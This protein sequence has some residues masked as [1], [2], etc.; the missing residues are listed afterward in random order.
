MSI[1]SSINGVAPIWW[2]ESVLFPKLWS[3][4]N[5]ISREGYVI[6]PFF[7]YL[8]LLI[9][10]WSHLLH[11]CLPLKCNVCF[12][13]DLAGALK[14]I[15]VISRYNNWLLYNK[16]SV[17]KVLIS[18][19]EIIMKSKFVGFLEPKVMLLEKLV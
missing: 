5:V 3:V 11:T 8:K 9:P 4:H 15:A 13:N 18:N 10:I 12:M 17:I 6:R 7:H 16:P 19:I 2:R 1:E 14:I